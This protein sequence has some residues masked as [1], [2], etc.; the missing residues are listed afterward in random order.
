M[1]ALKKTL[2]IL[3]MVAVTSYT[4]RHMYLKWIEPRNSVLDKYEEPIVSEIKKAT[5]L[6]QLETIF[7]EAQNR[8]KE[9]EAVDSIMAMDHYKRRELEPYK[10]ENE[11]R[12][13]IQSW[14]R[15][16]HEIFQIRFYWALGLLLAIVGF[17]IFKK[18]NDWL[19]ISILIT[20]FAE[21][22]YWS[23]PSF[24]NGAEFEYNNLL[25]NKII[26]SVLTLA[27][28]IIGGILTGTLKSDNK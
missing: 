25:T 14:E 10:T 12:N 7:S 21:M 3:S 28:L 13:A 1:E 16:S 11:A 17:M 26:L 20:G 9:Y 2:F 23:S 22:V 18:V 15:R 5:S 8:I 6:Q 24:F 19:G 4:I 27:L